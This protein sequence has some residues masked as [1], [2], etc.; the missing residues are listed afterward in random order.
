MAKPAFDGDCV[1]WRRVNPLY[2][3]Q[4]IDQ[5][6]IA[7][8]KLSQAAPTWAQAY[9]IDYSGGLEGKNFT[10]DGYG[11][12]SDTGGAVGANL[13]TGRL[14]EGDNRYDFRL[15]DSDFGGLF[16]DPTFFGTAAKDFSYI[17]DFDNGLTANDASC[18]LAVEGFGIAPS[19]KYCNLGRGP[20][21]ASTAGG[22]SG[23]PQFGADGRLLSIT[24]YGL[25]FGKDFGDIDNSLNDTFGEFNGFVPL[26]LHR[27]FIQAAVPEPETWAMMIMGFGFA[28]LA[29]RARNRKVVYA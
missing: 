25:T 7:I 8:V 22:D 10:F 9:D 6:D 14:R 29:M 20:R 11:R 13:G 21:E 24:S 3:G 28:G 1:E 17:S 27:S 26:F 18:V 5:N 19:G 12:R 23:G 2:T 15:G 4:V 16:T